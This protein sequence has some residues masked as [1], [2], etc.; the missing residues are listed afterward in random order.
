MSRTADG[1]SPKR[2]HGEAQSG[3]C[4]QNF[5]PEVVALPEGGNEADR[6]RMI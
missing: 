6:D 4:S 2:R 5:L 3:G 1:R